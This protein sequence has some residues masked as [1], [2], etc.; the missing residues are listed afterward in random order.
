MTWSS[1]PVHKQSC[2]P[3]GSATRY[4]HARLVPGFAVL[5]N[6]SPT[7]SLETWKLMRTLFNKHCKR[8]PA[9]DRASPCLSC[10]SRAGQAV[11]QLER[12]HWIL[13]SCFTTRSYKGVGGW[14]YL[15]VNPWYCILKKKK[16]EL[17]WW[18]SFIL[19]Q[20]KLSLVWRW[21]CNSTCCTDMAFFHRWPCTAPESATLASY[22]YRLLLVQICVRFDL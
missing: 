5:R 18:G 15:C 7:L 17:A 13:V 21:W 22:S 19:I 20:T 10:A 6:V 11:Q 12:C 1:G 8:L 4:V 3:S 2:S 9:A 14:A 16:S